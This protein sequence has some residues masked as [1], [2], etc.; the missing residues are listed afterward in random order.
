[1]EACQKINVF[2]FL[3]QGSSR[4]ELQGSLQASEDVTPQFL[5]EQDVCLLDLGAGM[6]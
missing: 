5:D 6:V 1:V 2:K 3:F 4:P